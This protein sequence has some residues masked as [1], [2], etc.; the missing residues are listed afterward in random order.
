M[1]GYFLQ[2]FTAIRSA[3]VILGVI[4]SRLLDENWRRAI[5]STREDFGAMMMGIFTSPLS[6][7][8][9]LAVVMILV[10]NSPWW[11]R[12]RARKARQ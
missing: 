7:A 8:L 9:L 11:A 4:L 6:L 2:G 12:W 5:I 1:L 10:T 3:P